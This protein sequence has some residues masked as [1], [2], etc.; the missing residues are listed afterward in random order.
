MRLTSRPVAGSTAV[1][2]SAS[3]QSAELAAKAIMVTEV[4]PIVPALV[5]LCSALRRAWLKSL[6][7]GSQHPN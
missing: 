7:G 2:V 6:R 1:W 4:W 3:R 5:M